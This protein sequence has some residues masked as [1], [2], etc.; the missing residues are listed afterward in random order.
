MQKRYS[1]TPVLSGKKNQTHEAAL[2]LSHTISSVSKL[3][4]STSSEFQ[5]G[6]FPSQTWM[7]YTLDLLLLKENYCSFLWALWKFWNSAQAAGRNTS[8]SGT[9]NTAG[10]PPNRAVA[11]RDDALC[12]HTQHG[13]AQ[14]KGILTLKCNHTKL[15]FWTMLMVDSSQLD[16]RLHVFYSTLAVTSEYIRSHQ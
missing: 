7:C 3:T 12:I 10:R 6:I 4:G 16:G 14:S 1:T 15:F 9:E 8:H 5:T 13:K 11:L 2:Y